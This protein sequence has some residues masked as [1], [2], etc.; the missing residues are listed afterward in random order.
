MTSQDQPRG[1]RH[2]AGESSIVRRSSASHPRAPYPSE[3]AAVAFVLQPRLGSGTCIMARHHAVEAVHWRPRPGRPAPR[4]VAWTPAPSRVA[5]FRDAVSACAVM[6]ATLLH[7]RWP[8]RRWSG[9]G[10][11]GRRDGRTGA[12][13]R[14]TFAL[15]PSRRDECRCL[16]QWAGYA[17]WPSPVSTRLRSEPR[18]WLA[19]AG[20]PAPP[21]RVRGAR[22]GAGSYSCLDLKPGGEQLAERLK[23][24]RKIAGGPPLHD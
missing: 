12:C 24:L 15:D 17:A 11:T 20:A 13:A 3:A 2:P 22:S 5:V 7:P 18:S 23:A 14:L 10:R 4:P 8:A 6:R 9:A 1:H 19:E 16:T 21:L